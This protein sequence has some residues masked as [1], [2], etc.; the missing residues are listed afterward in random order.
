MSENEG[1][2]PTPASAAAYVHHLIDEAARQRLPDLF[3]AEHPDAIYRTTRNGVTVL[4]LRTPSLTEEQ[5]VKLLRFRLAQYLAVHFIDGQMVYEARMEHEPLANVLPDDVHFLAGAADTG[6]ILCYAV[7]KAPP[8]APPGTT[9]RQRDRPLFPVEKTHGWGV[10]NRLRVLPDLPFGK[11]RELGRF[12]KNQRLHTL[13]ELAV[14]GPV[15]VVASVFRTLIGPLRLEV[16]AFIGDLEEGVALQNFEFFHCPIV[17]IHGTVPYEPEEAYFFPRYQNCNVYPF[18][19]LMADLQDNLLERLAAIEEALDKPGKAGLLALFALKRITAAPRSGLEPPGGLAPLSEQGLPQR[20]VAMRDRRQLLDAGARLRTTDLFASLSVAEAAVLGTF[21]E[22]LEVPA[23]Q[24]IVRQGEPGD[25]LYLIESGQARVQIT[26]R[27][28]AVSPMRS[29]AP[30]DY[31]GEIALLMGGERTA[32]VIA[33]TPMTLLR[34]SKEAYTRYLG[35]AAEVEQRITR[36]AV[37][38]TYASA[39]QMMGGNE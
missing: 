32:D 30:G 38:R 6:E 33:E 8:E 23:G 39:R 11:I 17:L 7:L 34:L 15:E 28:G 27:S 9:L 5:L 12:V 37:S 3:G 18:A 22:R 31:F 26:H 19:V 36:T 29:L 35:H 14:R 24:V 1:P 16:E 25:D 10:F 21:M 2:D 20:D 13:H 4:V